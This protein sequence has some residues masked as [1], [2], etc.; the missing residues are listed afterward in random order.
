M[1][2]P[3]EPKLP[4]VYYS[5]EYMTRVIMYEEFEKW[6]IRPTSNAASGEVD[7][8][9]IDKI[10]EKYCAEHTDQQRMKQAI[11]EATKDLM[12]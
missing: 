10:V 3:P 8:V 5:N 7:D 6:N 4:K 2:P 12:G 11:L 9:R 1:T